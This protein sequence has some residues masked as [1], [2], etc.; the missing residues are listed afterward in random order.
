LR[1]VVALVV[2]KGTKAKRAQAVISND[3]L[4]VGILRHLCARAPADS[5][6][7]PCSYSTYRSLLVK[8][9]SALGIDFGWTPHSPRA[10]FAS[11]AIQDG[12]PFQQ[13]KESGRWLVDSSLRTY[14]DL[15]R[16]SQ[17]SVDVQA[18]GLLPAVAFAD[19]NLFRFFP[20]LAEDCGELFAS[21]SH[22]GLQG[23]TQGSGQ[24]LLPS[25]GREQRPT[26]GGL[27]DSDEGGEEATDKDFNPTT[28]T[29]KAVS[30]ATTIASSP[31]TPSA[32]R[33]RSSSRQGPPQGRGKGRGRSSR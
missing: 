14:I 21:G 11:E 10:G 15:V 33:S 26:P 27:S 5:P 4:T 25:V 7:I 17:L 29:S 9:Q 24:S 30:F 32:T 12:I 13:V 22:G 6:I 31:E 1:V 28:S 20:G 19:Q 18:K 8:A 2:R 16:V 23:Q 3:P